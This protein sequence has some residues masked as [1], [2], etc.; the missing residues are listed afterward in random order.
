MGLVRLEENVHVAKACHR[1]R[2]TRHQTLDDTMELFDEP[3]GLALKADCVRSTSMTNH[4]VSQR[5][6]PIHGS[7]CGNLWPC[8]HLGE[9]MTGGL[10]DP[11]VDGLNS[12][13]DLYV[14]GPVVGAVS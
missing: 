3:P 13:G 6:R 11:L 7:L 1:R 12:T 2:D 4:A 14:V 10:R 5:Q 9:S 8:G